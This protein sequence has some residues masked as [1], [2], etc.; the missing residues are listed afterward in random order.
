MNALT[1]NKDMVA[2]SGAAPGASKA[3]L[4][5]LKRGL[6]ALE[7]LNCESMINSTKLAAIM[8]LPRTTARRILDTLVAEGYAEKISFPSCYRLTPRV[9]RLSHGLS[10]DII[11]S[12]V[13]TPLLAAATKKFGWTFAVATPHGDSMII[14]VTT[15][16]ISPY[17]TNRV[18]VGTR[19]PI[20]ASQCGRLAVAYMQDAERSQLSTGPVEGYQQPMHD[21]W[22]D[23]YE[24]IRDRGCVYPPVAPGRRRNVVCVPIFLDGQVSAALAMNYFSSAVGRAQLESEYIPMLKDLA[25]DIARKAGEARASAI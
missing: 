11:L 7:I 12:H 23:S 25:A 4:S 13:A 16:C 18:G 6:Q 21:F 14:Q 17:S 9:A 2:A 10:D 8:D 20:T 5:T 19:L 22:Q 1:N 15:D 3:E 24:Q